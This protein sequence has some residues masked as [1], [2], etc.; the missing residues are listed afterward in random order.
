MKRGKTF[1]LRKHTLISFSPAVGS[2]SCGRKKKTS[3]AVLKWTVKTKCKYG[4][5]RR[6]LFPS[7]NDTD[8]MANFKQIFKIIMKTYKAVTF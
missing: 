7:N 6:L 5:L 1:D 4:S 3:V 8:F 2:T